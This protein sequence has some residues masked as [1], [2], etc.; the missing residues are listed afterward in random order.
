[1]WQST[2]AVCQMRMLQLCGA[3]KRNEFS[4]IFS[5]FIVAALNFTLFILRWISNHRHP[6]ERDMEKS[7]RSGKW[8][9]AGGEQ[10]WRWKE[11][12]AAE[13]EEW[14]RRR[15]KRVAREKITGRKARRYDRV[16]I[17]PR[18]RLNEEEEKKRED[19]RIGRIIAR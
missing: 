1:M 11:N 5:S 12:K 13:G 14:E 7:C 19:E 3:Y 2:R 10:R 16:A 9:W 18:E 6:A 8:R 4:N 15:V 17:F